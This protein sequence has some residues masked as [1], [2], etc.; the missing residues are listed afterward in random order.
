MSMENVVS[1]DTTEENLT[2]NLV[3]RESVSQPRTFVPYLHN[4]MIF[5]TEHPIT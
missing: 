3:V 1:L 4:T 2:G 5:Y